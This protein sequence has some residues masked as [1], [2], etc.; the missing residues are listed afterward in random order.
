MDGGAPNFHKFWFFISH[1]EAMI[2]K[3]RSWYDK[4][5]SERTTLVVAGTG[6]MYVDLVLTINNQRR[7]ASWGMALSESLPRIDV[8]FHTAFL[9]ITILF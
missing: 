7:I 8:W 4:Q 2:K 6:A 3:M 1:N 9:S 5:S